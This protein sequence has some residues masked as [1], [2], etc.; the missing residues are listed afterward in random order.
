MTR[1]IGLRTIRANNNISSILLAIHLHPRMILRLKIPSNRTPKSHI[2]TILPRRIQKNLMQITPMHIITRRIFPYLGYVGALGGGHC[3]C[4]EEFSV[5]AV[6]FEV[7]HVATE[8]IDQVVDA[9]A[10]NQTACVGTDSLQQHQHPTTTAGKRGA[11]TSVS[12]TISRYSG[13]EKGRGSGIGER[14]GDLV[15]ILMISGAFSK[16]M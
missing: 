9:P 11:S 15:P 7:I 2:S 6:D 4:G 3:L 12:P 1:G 16:T 5:V 13:E 14:E 10:V 8:G